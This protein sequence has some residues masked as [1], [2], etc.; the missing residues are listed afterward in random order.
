[1]SPGCK[2][3]TNTC[4]SFATRLGW[5]YT[6]VDFVSP[7]PEIQYCTYAILNQIIFWNSIN[8]QCARIR[9]RWWNEVSTRISYLDYCDFRR[10]P[11]TNMENRK[12]WGCVH[13]PFGDMF[14][15]FGHGFHHGICKCW[16]TVQSVRHWLADGS[17][18]VLLSE[19]WFTC[20]VG[21]NEID[22]N[23]KSMFQYLGVLRIGITCSE[24][25]S[26]IDFNS[27]DIATSHGWCCKWVRDV[28]YV[29]ISLRPSKIGTVM[30]PK[31][32][33]LSRTWSRQT[34]STM[35]NKLSWRVCALDLFDFFHLFPQNFPAYKR[36]WESLE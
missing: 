25:A 19:P 28:G 13:I 30:L 31:S 22:V 34:L 29:T 33:R 21:T 10:S 8:W 23:H 11:N 2:K 17:F 36:N 35:D 12:L 24:N 9:R 5:G 16:G 4:H 15:L 26:W 27:A 6:K 1:M 14:R 32:L 18:E 7:C 20:L 3:V